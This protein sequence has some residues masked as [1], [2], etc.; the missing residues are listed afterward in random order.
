M[1]DRLR[2]AAIEAV[3][4]WDAWL[5]APGWDNN[6]YDLLTDAMEA[7]KAILREEAGYANCAEH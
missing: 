6:E 7:V 4:S 2:A 1:T 3:K 5:D